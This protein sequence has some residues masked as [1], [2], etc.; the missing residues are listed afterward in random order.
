MQVEYLLFKSLASEGFQISDV[1]MFTIFNE[2]PSR[3]D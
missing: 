2:T 3:W 1:G